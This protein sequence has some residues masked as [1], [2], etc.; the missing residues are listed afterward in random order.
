MPP[1]AK[2]PG[3]LARLIVAGKLREGQFIW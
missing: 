1:F 3:E 2:S